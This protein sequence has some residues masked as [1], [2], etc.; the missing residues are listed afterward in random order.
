MINRIGELYKHIMSDSKNRRNA[1]ISGVGI[2]ILI[3]LIAPTVI[4]SAYSVM[5]ADDFSAGSMFKR[6]Y[7]GFNYIKYYYNSWQGTYTGLGII[8]ILSPILH[9]GLDGLKY[10][11]VINSIAL[12]GSFIFLCDS[13]LKEVFG[14][15]AL[16]TR[17]LFILLSVFVFT[18][19][20]SYYEGIYWFTG[21]AVYTMP[22]IITMV[23]VALFIR[24]NVRINI[25]YA[26]L[27][28]LLGF[29]GMGGSLIIS[30]FGCYA[31][32]LLVVYF[33]IKA[34]KINIW[35]ICI[36]AVW[37]IGAL[38]NVAAPGNY[39]RHDVADSSGIHPLSAI[40]TSIK[41]YVSR[42]EWFNSN[43]SIWTVFMLMILCGLLFYEAKGLSVKNIALMLC[44][45]ILLPFVAVFPVALGQGDN[46][47]N[48]VLFVLDVAIIFVLL[49][50]S[51]LVSDFIKHN[52]MTEEN[53]KLIITFMV[54]IIFT[55]MALDNFTYENN[56][57]Y[58]VASQLKDGVFQDYH[59]AVSKIL[60]KLDTY[61]EGSD[62]VVSLQEMPADIENYK[63][64][65]IDMDP[66]DWVNVDMSNYYGF[67]SLRVE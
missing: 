8:A 6:G 51:L 55:S 62:V 39:V 61:E 67:N 17:V 50:M 52:V 36:F 34:K 26:V 64:F 33:A 44:G 60:D 3:V 22:L 29:L 56:V 1:L 15:K 13:V 31:L 5:I 25:V 9:G 24:K 16:V 32:L 10:I 27:I 48:R 11:A 63:N 57:S 18:A 43:T 21:M 41:V 2:L 47:P 12:F 46:M 65:Y 30:G 38:V 28:S 54:V 42:I 66:A 53:R 49:V 4:S 59:S 37:V 23:G 40:I 58:K 19:Y 20:N 45:T 7:T 35:H 14:Q